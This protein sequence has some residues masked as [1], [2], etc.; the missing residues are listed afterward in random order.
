VVVIGATAVIEINFV[1]GIYSQN[2]VD[3]S[4]PP[5]NPTF[6]GTAP[7]ILVAAA[8]MENCDGSDHFQ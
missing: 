5:G 4:L 3:W 8:A 7:G 1:N 6:I 2:G